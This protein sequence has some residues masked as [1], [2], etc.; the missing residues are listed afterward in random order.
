MACKN[1]LNIYIFNDIST[2]V[3]GKTCPFVKSI[4]TQTNFVWGIVLFNLPVAALSR[5]DIPNK[6][7]RDIR[8]IWG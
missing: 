5:R 3:C 6:F 7:P 2:Q 4:W 1:L 8:C